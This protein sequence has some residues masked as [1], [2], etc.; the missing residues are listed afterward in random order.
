V[1]LRVD[2]RDAAERITISVLNGRGDPVDVPSPLVPN[3]FKCPWPAGAYR[4]DA[5]VEPD[6]PSIPG[7]YRDVLPPF[8]RYPV[9]VAP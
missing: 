8:W 5:N 2:P 3:P 6:G 1:T 7:E 9:Q 4:V